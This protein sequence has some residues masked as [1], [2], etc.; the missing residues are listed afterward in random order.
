MRDRRRFVTIALFLFLLNYGSS[1]CRTTDS[2]ARGSNNCNSG[3]SRTI[4]TNVCDEVIDVD[5]LKD[6]GEKAWP[7]RFNAHVHCLHQCS[8]LLSSDRDSIVVEDQ[9]S[10]SSCDFTGGHWN[11]DDSALN[12]G[13]RVWG[14]VDYLLFI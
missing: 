11:Q 9:C 7:I 5:L 14:C 4:G 3:T 8:N 10:V 13:A 1:R 2:R 6:L 12:L